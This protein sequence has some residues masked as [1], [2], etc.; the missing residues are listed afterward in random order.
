[1]LDAFNTTMSLLLSALSSWA[2]LSCRVRDGIIVKIG[3]A[4]ISIGFLSLFMLALDP[5]GR[6]PLAFANALVHIGLVICV[7]GY[8]VRNIRKRPRAGQG[9][10]KRRLADWVDLP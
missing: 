4:C 3:L 8:L 10:R 9:T 5:G 2:I 1:M 7:A 6:Q